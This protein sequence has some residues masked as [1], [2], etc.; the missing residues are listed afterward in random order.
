MARQLPGE[1][2]GCV[3]EPVSREQSGSGE[4][5]ERSWDIWCGLSWVEMYRLTLHILFASLAH[6][7]CG[8]PDKSKVA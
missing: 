2:C 4:E 1:R 6:F 5:G 8:E 3:N 7:C